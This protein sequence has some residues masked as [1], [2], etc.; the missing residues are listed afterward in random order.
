MNSRATAIIS[1]LEAAGIPISLDCPRP[2]TYT[3]TLLDASKNITLVEV[4]ESPRYNDARVQGAEEALKAIVEKYLEWPPL[5]V[6]LSACTVENFLFDSRSVARASMPV[7]GRDIRFMRGR[8]WEVLPEEVRVIFD[9][10]GDAAVTPLYLE[11]LKEVGGEFLAAKVSGAE[12]DVKAAQASL[13]ALKKVEAL[14]Q[15]K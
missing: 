2:Q 13:E 14:I 12:S 9:W 15:E 3:V 4:F 10:R 5:H 8:K 7:T 6:E 1:A 11:R